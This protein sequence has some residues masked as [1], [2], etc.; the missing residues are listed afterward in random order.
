MVRK[1]V[2]KQTLLKENKAELYIQQLN[3]NDNKH[4]QD[5]VEELDERFTAFTVYLQNYLDINKYD[6]QFDAVIKI[7][8]N[9]KF[10]K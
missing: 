6:K 2:K 4:F 9:V 10:E 1:E 3:K 8:R 7:F 5:F